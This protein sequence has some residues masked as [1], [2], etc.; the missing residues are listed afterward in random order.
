VDKCCNKFK[1]PTGNP[2]D[3]KR[4]MTLRCQRIQEWILKKSASSIM[5]ADSEGGKGLELSE[6]S[7]LALALN[8]DDDDAVD[9]ADPHLYGDGYGA[10]VAGGLMADEQVVVEE[11]AGGIGRRTQSRA[12]T[13]AYVGDGDA[14]ADSGIGIMATEQLHIALM[15]PPNL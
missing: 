6:D 15:P 1:R 2:G 14:D 12:A 13:P 8:G 3:P 4:D 5:C 9:A 7:L 10:A 11:L